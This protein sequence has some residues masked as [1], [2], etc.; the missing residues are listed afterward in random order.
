IWGKPT[1]GTYWVWDARLTS[2]LIMFFLY[3]GVIALINAI[4][5][6]RQAGRAAGL[7]SVVGVINVVIVK[8][9]VE[10]WHSLHQGSTLKIIGDTSMPPAMLI[11][12]LISMLGIYL[13]FAVSVLW[14]ARAELL[15]RERKSAWVRERI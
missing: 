6:P 1:W 5:D 2:M 14:R 4:P 7:L 12:L 8:Y 10:W 11:P 3:L 13:L 15:W 9:S